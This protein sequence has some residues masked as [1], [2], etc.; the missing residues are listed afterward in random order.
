MVQQDGL[1][2]K[3][4]SSL[5]NEGAT[6]LRIKKLKQ[7]F[8]KCL[9]WLPKGYVASN[10]GDI[11]ELITKLNRNE[12]KR[13][14]GGDFSGSTKS[15]IKKFLRQFY[16]WLKGDNEHYPPEVA[17]IKT[18]ISKDE[19]PEEKPVLSVEDAE[20]FALS[21][22]SIEYR[23]IIYV[24]FDSGFRISELLSVKKQDVTWENYD[25]NGEKCFWIKCNESKT[26]TRKIPIPLFTE[27]V[28]LFLRNKHIRKLS[29]DDLLFS[30]KYP[31]I[32]K[33]MRK[34]SLKLFGKR[35]TPHALRHSSATYYAREL[36]GNVPQLAQRFGWSYSAKELQ[37][38]VRAS[39]AYQ[40]QSV[41]K[42]FSNQATELKTENEQLR[43]EVELM[44]QQ[45]EQLLIIAEDYR[46]NTSIKE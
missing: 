43:K 29:D 26:V 28:R 24:L 2:E 7:M 39:G 11:E 6:K 27:K 37:T 22:D 41:K 35:I 21:F 15:D 18:K 31:N 19:K 17:W 9:Q 32:V 13:Q 36:D 14:D 40:K 5:L 45:I 3:Y 33:A 4:E 20:R 12:I 8:F 30:A 44:K 38:Y 1:W 25:E 34:N 10:R 42:V 46:R 23:T 16:K